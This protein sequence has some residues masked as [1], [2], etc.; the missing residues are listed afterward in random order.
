MALADV[1]DQILLA[2]L[3]G[4]ASYIAAPAAI[5]SSMPEA[6]PSLYLAMPLALTFPLNL[7]FGI[8]L[9]MEIHDGLARSAN[10]FSAAAW[11]F[12]RTKRI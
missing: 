7:L 1:V 9:Y 12:S 8:G 6:N 5:K 11:L 10:S 2:V 3:A 4:S